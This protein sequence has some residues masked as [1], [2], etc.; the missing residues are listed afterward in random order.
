MVRAALV[1]L[2]RRQANGV[3]VVSPSG[4][5]RLNLNRWPRSPAPRLPDFAQL[6]RCLLEIT[7]RNDI[8]RE[9]GLP[10]L[11][12]VPELRRMKRAEME[13]EFERFQ[14]A[15]GR[16]VFEEMLRE[17]RRDP[18]WRPTWMQAWLSRTAFAAFCWSSSIRRGGQEQLS[19]RINP[20]EGFYFA[21]PQAMRAPPPPRVA[22]WSE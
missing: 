1:C 12:P 17:A 10:L 14:A 21:T 15:H 11:S 2:K 16:T 19:V 5:E 9:A 13:E 20:F 3:H 8:Q 7:R 22:G 18:Y 6:A 4:C